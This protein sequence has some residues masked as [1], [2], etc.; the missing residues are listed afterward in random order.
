M[1]IDFIFHTHDRVALFFAQNQELIYAKV[2]MS[3]L[4]TAEICIDK[5]ETYRLSADCSF[6][7]EGFDSF[8]R[9]SVFIKPKDGQ[10]AKGAKLI[11]S[12]E[13]IL[14]DIN[15]ENIVI[16]QNLPD[17]EMIVDCLTDAYGNP[18]ACLPRSRIL[19][20][21]RV[22]VVSKAKQTTDEIMQIVVTIN[23]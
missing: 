17:Q 19:L 15:I 18:V 10:E 6:C 3:N 14:A 7:L 4:Y 11:T 8:S 13:D 20:M 9:F 22:C 16:C 1:K 21:V 23:N 5:Y 2:I 12:R